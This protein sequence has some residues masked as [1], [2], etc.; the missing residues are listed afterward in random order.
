M[1]DNQQIGNA[2]Q[3]KSMLERTFEQV[4]G[5]AKEAME[6]P[7]A[8]SGLR[9][10]D[11]LIV[12]W[13]RPLLVVVTGE[14]GAGR[15]ALAGHIAV[16]QATDGHVVLYSIDLPAHTLVTRLITSRA[17]VDGARVLN[18]QANEREWE[19]MAHAAGWLEARDIDVVEAY[20]LT[21]DEIAADALARR[22]N[23]PVNLVMVDGI[24]LLDHESPADLDR[25]VLRLRKLSR[26]LG[27]AVIVTLPLGEEV[28]KRIARVG[29][30]SDLSVST[31]SAADIVISLYRPEMYYKESDMQGIAVLDVLKQKT[32]PLGQ[33]RLFFSDIHV[34]FNDMGNEQ[35]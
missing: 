7:P 27:C 12:D 4:V 6:S 24:E 8:F 25:S 20:D 22:Q 10:L 23:R 29:I 30:L 33:A 17:H 11:R 28:Q 19:R 21:V 3:G 18:G 5:V 32:G 34:R 31:G 13:R 15:S 1:S 9:A 2:E 16:H 35:A 14:S 26:E